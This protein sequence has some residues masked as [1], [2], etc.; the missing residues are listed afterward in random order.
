MDSLSLIRL[1]Y[2][3]LKD[4]YTEPYMKKNE[5]TFR[6]NKTKIKKRR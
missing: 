3:E 6:R 5:R 1:E 4:E 2:K